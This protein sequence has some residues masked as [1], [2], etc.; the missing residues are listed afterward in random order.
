MHFPSQSTNDGRLLTSRAA[1]LA[2]TSPD[3]QAMRPSA[4]ATPLVNTPIH[5]LASTVEINN[6]IYKT[7]QYYLIFRKFFTKNT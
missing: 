3:A 6:C 4:S 5:G 1:F 2:M 7:E